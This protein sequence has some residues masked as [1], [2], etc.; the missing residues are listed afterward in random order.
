MCGPAPLERAASE[1]S[2][3]MGASCG[4]SGPTP[5]SHARLPPSLS[6]S[7]FSPQF[8]F[9]VCVPSFFSLSLLCMPNP[10]ALFRLHS[11]HKGF[12]GSWI[13][14][15]WKVKAPPPPSP[16]KR[17]FFHP[18]TATHDFQFQEIKNK[19]HLLFDPRFI[20]F[21][22][23]HCLHLSLSL[24]TTTTT[25]AAAAAEFCLFIL[26]F[27]T[28]MEFGFANKSRS[29]ITRVD[30]STL[31]ANGRRVVNWLR[32]RRPQHK[33]ARA[34]CYM[35]TCPTEENSLSSQS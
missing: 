25:A 30:E 22:F 3:N 5:H 17:A 33:A 2:G 4:A 12:N 32:R 6:L 26:L 1:T 13:T 29:F 8:F 23:V 27:G 28:W 15:E 14:L 24:K 11:C 35:H 19:K 21:F 34:D 20:R 16:L 7:L 9:C 31:N 10:P 18:R